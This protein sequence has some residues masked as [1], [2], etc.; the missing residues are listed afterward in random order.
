MN[1]PTLRLTLDVRGDGLYTEFTGKVIGTLK[2]K[3]YE[4]DNTGPGFAEARYYL[5]HW[6]EHLHGMI[7][8]DGLFVDSLHQE[9]H[10]YGFK[11]YDNVDYSEAG[12]QGSDYVSMDASYQLAREVQDRGYNINIYSDDQP[13]DLNT[14][15]ANSVHK[16]LIPEEKPQN[17]TVKQL[18]A[19]MD[20][21]LDEMLAS[22]D[23]LK[24][25]VCK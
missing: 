1:K 10:K 22:I 19:D 14:H 16:T 17:D 23:R 4:P 11:H 20:Q 9:L 24:G 5:D 13:A 2:F 8:T 3:I 6:N 12:M 7:Y 18:F 15:V 21:A 25:A